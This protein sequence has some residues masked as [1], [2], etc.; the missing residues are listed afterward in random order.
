LKAHNTV[1]S[2]GGTTAR[3]QPSQSK[4]TPHSPTAKH[5]H[6]STMTRRAPQTHTAAGDRSSVSASNRASGP[7]SRSFPAANVVAIAP[8]RARA[9]LSA[10]QAESILWAIFALSLP[11]ALVVEH[12]ALRGTR[13]VQLVHATL[14]AICS[15]VYCCA[16]GICIGLLLSW[17]TAAQYGLCLGLNIVLSPDNLLVFMMYM[18]SSQLPQELQRKVISH[19]MLFAV[20]LRCL[21]MLGGAALLQRFEW[22]QVVLALIIFS[23]GAK[24]LFEGDDTPEQQQAHDASTHWAVRS[25]SRVL[26]LHWRDDDTG[27]YF[28]VD[29]AGRILLS[30][31]AALVVAIGLTDL[32]FA[33]DSISMV[34]ATTRSSF[35][36]VVSQALSMLVLRSIYFMIASL[37]GVFDSLNT[38]LG[39]VLVLIGLKLM[40]E[41]AGVE[42]PLW[43]FAGVLSLWRVAVALHVVWRRGGISGQT[44]PMVGGVE[45][46]RL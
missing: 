7:K 20:A 27:S 33:L 34:L 41:L 38:A 43:L 3:H 44:E 2:H 11:I 18:C 40:L 42:V 39:F 32:S 1:S 24:M 15:L 4:R 36:M 10:S 30:R 28:I 46:D 8:H 45:P 17:G 25:L 37:M 31:V 22:L 6:N 13:N 35:V 14:W 23:S 12:F 9:Q 5:A 16:I 19:G 26:P 29:G 21:A